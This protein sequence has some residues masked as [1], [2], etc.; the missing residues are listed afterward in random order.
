MNAAFAG[1]SSAPEGLVGFNECIGTAEAYI[2]QLVF[3]QI[4]ELLS[5]AC[6]LPPESE[7]IA[8]AG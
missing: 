4:A 1:S 2:A 6:A 5:A 8:G 7:D 3:S